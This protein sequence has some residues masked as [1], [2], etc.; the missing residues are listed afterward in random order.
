MVH[1]DISEHIVERTDADFSVFRVLLGYIGIQV[2]G[3]FNVVLNN[4]LGILIESHLFSYELRICL[5]GNSSGLV[6]DTEIFLIISDEENCLF[7]AGRKLGH[8]R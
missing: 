3:V 1:D 2:E 7:R 6:V 5:L 4:H 8:S